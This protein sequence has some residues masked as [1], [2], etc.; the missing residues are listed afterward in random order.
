[1]TFPN[2]FIRDLLQLARPASLSCAK[3]GAVAIRKTESAFGAHLIV[4]TQMSVRF[5][6][7]L[8]AF[9]TCLNTPLR[10]SLNADGANFINQSLYSSTDFHES[11][12][13]ISVRFMLAVSLSIEQSYKKKSTRQNFCEVLLVSFKSQVSGASESAVWLPTSSFPLDCGRRF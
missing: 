8:K 13:Q 2:V 4:L 5:C 12:F 6:V 9:L 7:E 1:M 3:G 10:A 11:S